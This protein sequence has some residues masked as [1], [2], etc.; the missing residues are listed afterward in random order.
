MLGPVER[1]EHLILPETTWREKVANKKRSHP[2]SRIQNNSIRA[3][4]FTRTIVLRRPINDV[5]KKAIS[6]AIKHATKGTVTSR[7][8]KGAIS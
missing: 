1:I 3:F 4:F 6:T 7:R 8:R 2:L 5:G